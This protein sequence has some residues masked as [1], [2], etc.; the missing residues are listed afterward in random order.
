MDIGKNYLYDKAF[1]PFS[2]EVLPG[3]TKRMPKVSCVIL[4]VMHYEDMQLYTI[5]S[6][7]YVFILFKF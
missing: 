2:G 3:L 4:P 6:F 1:F 5:S 7:C